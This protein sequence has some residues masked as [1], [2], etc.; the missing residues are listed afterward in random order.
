MSFSDTAT[1][2]LASQPESK[3]RIAREIIECRKALAQMRPDADS[4]VHR[5][6]ESGVITGLLRALSCL[7]DRPGDIS[8]TGAG[9]YVTTVESA[10]DMAAEADA[11]GDSEH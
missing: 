11:P 5:W 6:S 7:G 3:L 2:W 9:G 10:D 1:K 4:D 8:D